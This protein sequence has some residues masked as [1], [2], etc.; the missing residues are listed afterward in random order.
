MKLYVGE[1]TQEQIVPDACHPVYETA[2][3]DKRAELKGDEERGAGQPRL[4]MT[5]YMLLDN[6]KAC[7]DETNALLVEVHRTGVGIE[8]RCGVLVNPL[9]ER[10]ENLY[11]D[12]S[13]ILRL[14]WRSGLWTRDAVDEEIAADGSTYQVLRA[15]FTDGKPHGRSLPPNT[16]PWQR[17]LLGLPAAQGDDAP[18]FVFAAALSGV[19]AAAALA[20][21]SPGEERSSRLTETEELYKA[22]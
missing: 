15:P 5:P 3:R 10:L 19:N 4:V 18:P 1:N 2:A 11:F 13:N 20:T 22:A 21:Q 17:D 16:P 6:L 12:M 8:R 9:A 7:Q 14:L